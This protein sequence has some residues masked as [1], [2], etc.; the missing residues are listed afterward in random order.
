MLGHDVIRNCEP[1]ARPSGPRIKDPTN[2]LRLQTGINLE[3]PL[4]MISRS[5]EEYHSIG[6]V[7]QNTRPT[8]V[9]ELVSES[10]HMYLV[11][12]AV[13]EKIVVKRLHSALQVLVL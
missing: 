6:L 7:Q 2:L 11:L 12:P 1:K 5:V 3:I 4:N 9:H 13:R 8:V 10:Y